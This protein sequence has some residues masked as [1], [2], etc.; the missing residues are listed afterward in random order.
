MY[1]RIQKGSL[2][3]SSLLHV[4]IGNRFIRNL[5]GEAKRFKGTFTAN[6]KVFSNSFIT[7]KNG[8]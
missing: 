1:D 8:E 3:N 7:V 5:H 2:V 4:V 6:D